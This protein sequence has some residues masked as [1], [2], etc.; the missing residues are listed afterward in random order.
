MPTVCYLLVIF[1]SARV[2]SAV[3][4]PNL[5][6]SIKNTM[7]ILQASVWAQ[8]ISCLYC[9]KCWTR[10][11]VDEMG[12]VPGTIYSAGRDTSPCLPNGFLHFTQLFPLKKPYLH[13]LLTP[14]R[15]STTHEFCALIRS[16]WKEICLFASLI[17]ISWNGL[18]DLTS[19]DFERRKLCNIFNTVACSVWCFC[20]LCNK[21]VKETDINKASL[22]KIF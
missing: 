10:S 5:V 6:W 15:K 13:R 20:W 19:F 4:T 14:T 16:H 1:I 9:Y 21:S 17:K 22:L 8:F 2:K 18:N 12:W 3:I 11:K 7:S